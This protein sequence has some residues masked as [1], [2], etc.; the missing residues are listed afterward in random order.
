MRLIVFTLLLL[1]ACSHTED[2]PV[3]GVTPVRVP[4]LIEPLNQKATRLPSIS[5]RTMGGQVEAGIEAE[6]AYNDVA[7]RYNKLIDLYNCVK[8]SINNETE[9]KQCLGE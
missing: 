7:F 9:I 4:D 6:I 3:V 5:D 1:S 2:T 8:T